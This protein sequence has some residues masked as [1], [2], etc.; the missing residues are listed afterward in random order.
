MV[1]MGIST[2]DASQFAN[3]RRRNG[4]VFWCLACL[5]ACAILSLL[6]SFIPARQE[7]AGL[8]ALLG[9]FLSPQALSSVIS[10]IGI[11]GIAF[12]WFIV[13][14]ENRI[15]GVRYVTLV[16][17]L[18]PRFFRGYF[19]LYI[20]SALIGIF[21]GKRDMFWPVLYACLEMIFHTCL[22]ISACFKFVVYSEQ[23]ERIAFA[24]YFDNLYT[25]SSASEGVNSS[26]YQANLLMAAEYTHM[27][28][29]REHR[30]TLCVSMIRLWGASLWP[31]QDYLLAQP[32]HWTDA[33]KE[34][35]Q[36]E[37][38]C[39]QS[40]TMVSRI[41]A[42]HQVWTVLLEN[43]TTPERRAEI[44]TALLSVLQPTENP[45][46]RLPILLGLTQFLLQ[47]NHKAED[48][49]E[50]LARLVQRQECMVHEKELTGG[51]AAALMVYCCLPDTS[52]AEEGLQKLRIRLGPQIHALLQ[53]RIR[54]RSAQDDTI[55]CLF[56]Y[57]ECATRK[58]LHINLFRYLL[59]VN[60]WLYDPLWMPVS[61]F[62]MD[63][64]GWQLDMLLY[65][66][67][68]L[69]ERKG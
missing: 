49:V 14:A 31:G 30:R 25:Y 66:L 20:P 58:F 15:C 65:L 29:Q 62:A 59:W 22:I 27:L 12:G 48:A 67:T 51:L 16:E 55:S 40:D 64:A 3:M 34:C 39:C 17:W 46:V 60:E 47:C 37:Q 53:Y 23:R 21:A 69:Q 2:T 61:L 13:R 54:N 18:F 45:K 41:E 8:T 42:S 26:D 68:D 52:W 1:K 9:R 5:L 32:L 11:S 6:G 63:K 35:W 57:A 38:A 43:E 56:L 4:G 36:G 7:V 33:T 19:F 44:I 10:A 24:Y 50:E 28:L